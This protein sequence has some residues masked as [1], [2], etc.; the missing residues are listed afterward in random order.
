MLPGRKTLDIQNNS[1]NVDLPE[2]HMDNL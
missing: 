2:E 1:L